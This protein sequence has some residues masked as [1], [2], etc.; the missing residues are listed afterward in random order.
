M[1]PDVFPDG[2][3]VD[4]CEF[5]CGIGRETTLPLPKSLASRGES[6]I[7]RRR[8]LAAPHVLRILRRFRGRGVEVLPLAYHH[9]ATPSRYSLS[10]FL[11]SPSTSRHDQSRVHAWLGMPGTDRTVRI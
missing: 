6:D 10:D 3:C 2:R 4:I 11:L 1:V 7:S 5:L 8:T 9:R